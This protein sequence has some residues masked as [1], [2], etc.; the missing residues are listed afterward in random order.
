MLDRFDLLV[1]LRK[2]SLLLLYFGVCSFQLENCLLDFA[3]KSQ[4]LLSHLLA[5]HFNLRSLSLDFRRARF[6]L[7]QVALVRNLHLPDEGLLAR[8]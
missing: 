7:T 2:E 6:H 8:V 5:S 1:L 4:L 3:P